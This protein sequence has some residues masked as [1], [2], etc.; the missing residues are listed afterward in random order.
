[1]I[2]SKDKKYNFLC[3]AYASD[4]YNSDTKYFQVQYLEQLN[5]L[6]TEFYK[7]MISEKK[8]EISYEIYNCSYR[9]PAEFKLEIKEPKPTGPVFR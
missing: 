4:G 7:K 9:G 5:P 3:I 6:L 1:M 8:D 2:L